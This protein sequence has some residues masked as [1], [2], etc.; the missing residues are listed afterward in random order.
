MEGKG[1]LYYI[2]GSRYEGDFK[3]CKLEGIGI[4][5]YNNGECKGDIYEG[6]WK[7]CKQEGKGIYYYNYGD[8]EMGD[9]Y[10][11]NPVGR[12]IILTKNG[13]VKSKSY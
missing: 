7:N 13:K 12:H 2:N 3:N 10:D 6:E 5:Y 4:Y 8:R 1:I 11:S 9:Y